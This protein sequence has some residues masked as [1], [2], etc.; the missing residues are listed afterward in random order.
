M[1]KHEP[2]SKG[3]LSRLAKVSKVAAKIAG[4]HALHVIKKPLQKKETKKKN[5]SKHKTEIATDLFKTLASLKGSALKAAQLISMEFDF[6]PDEIKAELKKSYYDVPPLNKAIV[7][8]MIYSQLKSY[9]ETLFESFNLNAFRA[10]SIGQ[11]HECRRLSGEKCALK[12]QYPGISETIKSDIS[13]LKLLLLKVPIPLIKKASKLIK[14]YLS[15]LETRFYEESDY[16]LEKENLI[17]FRS[18]NPFK[19]IK[20]PKIYS[21]HC[22]SKVLCM[23]FMAAEPIDKWISL[24]P[25]QDKKNKI[26]QLIWDFFV[27]FLLKHNTIHADPNPGNYMIDKN[28]NLV[29][30]DFGCVKKFDNGFPQQIKKVV[31]YHLKKDMPKVMSIYNEWNIL[32][33][34]LKNDINKV[35]NYVKGFRSWITKPFKT[36]TFCFKK[37]KNH[38]NERFSKEFILGREIMYNPNHNFVMFDRNL[39]GIMNL[40]NNLEAEIHFHLDVNQ[41]NFT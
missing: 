41:C 12:V 16:L 15:E 1:T 4:K 10:A 35:E 14:T 34:H 39:M 8:R 6:F 24:N 13:V 28:I 27:Y 5:E 29:V 2:I 25:T 19:Y 22:S 3:R 17:W 23:E 31:S 18:V 40:L 11:V 36:P 21:E 33:D 7:R 20:I 26:G 9:P 38:M 30:I 37:N 32:P